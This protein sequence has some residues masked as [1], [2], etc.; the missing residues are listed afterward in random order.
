M[1]DILEQHCK[2]TIQFRTDIKEVPKKIIVEAGTGYDGS[3][4]FLFFSRFI[5]QIF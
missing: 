3:G 5:T 2:E 1:R 4:M